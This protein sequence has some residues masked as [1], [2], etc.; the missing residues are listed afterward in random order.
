MVVLGIAAYDLKCLCDTNILIMSEPFEN[1]IRKLQRVKQYLDNDA[2]TIIGVEAL[3]WFKKSFMDQGFTDQSLEKWEEVQ[4]RKPE[5]PWYGFQFGSNSKKP[6]KKTRGGT[7]NF[8]PAATQRPILSGTTQELINS[9]FWEKT[10][11]GVRVIAR[12]AHAK[13]QNEGGPMK[14]F[15]KHSA[16]MPKRQFMGPSK[17]LKEKLRSMILKDIKNILK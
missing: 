14:V 7:S 5:S 8:S 10:A 4:R 13:I 1:T 11:S 16:Q 2:K 6:G 17:Q 15:G 9:M 3:K 12:A